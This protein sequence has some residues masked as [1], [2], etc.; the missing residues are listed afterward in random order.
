MKFEDIERSV[1]RIQFKRTAIN[2]DRILA[3]A[4]AALEK[5]TRIESTLVG[6][7]VWRRLIDRKSVKLTAAAV[8]VLAALAGVYQLTEWR[9]NSSSRTQGSASGN[10]DELQ[11]IDL[12]YQGRTQETSSSNKDE[13]LSRTPLSLESLA[14]TGGSFAWGEPTL[15]ENVARSS[16]IVRAK[17]SQITDTLDERRG[18][19]HNSTG[20]LTVIEYFVT[21]WEITRHIY[22][23]ELED[24]H[25]D[26]LIIVVST[27]SGDPGTN[28]WLSAIAPGT[29]MILFIEKLDSELHL[30]WSRSE[31]PDEFEAEKL[32][33]DLYL[34]LSQGYWSQGESLDEFEAKIV[35]VI[36][37][38]AHLSA[39]PDSSKW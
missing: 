7:S 18:E 15:A 38:G 3:D 35:K 28:R 9:L 30:F 14:T 10:V 32:D 25:I 21:Q 1:R 31:P 34:Y 11:L 24:N 36:E 17:F 13:L 20:I 2:H 27:S 8:I 6:A 16:I 26:N 33:S 19:G 4:E 5:S 22:G 29:E 23:E 37:S 12:G 39:E